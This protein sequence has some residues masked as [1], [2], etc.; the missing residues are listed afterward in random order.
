MPLTLR[1]DDTV[2]TLNFVPYPSDLTLFN[3]ALDLLASQVDKHS[4]DGVPLTPWWSPCGNT[5]RKPLAQE[6]FKW[7]NL[8]FRETTA[9]LAPHQAHSVTGA[10]NE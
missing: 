3:N 5:P 2:K 1:A 6:T 8:V 10:I 7:C 9:H 4:D